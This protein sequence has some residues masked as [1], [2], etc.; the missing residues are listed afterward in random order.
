MAS[1]FDKTQF[2]AAPRD[3]R[4]RM[5]D[6]I[7][8]ALLTYT[9]I[10]IML[11]IEQLKRHDGTFLPY[12][13]LVVLVGGVMPACRWMERRWERIGPVGGLDP[14]FAPRFRK[15][16]ALLWLA[17]IALPCSIAALAR[18]A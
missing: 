18:I 10:Q 5:S 16:R 11:T 9:A 1:G 13:A 4:K 8:F 3:W 6:N 15:E 12:L 7:A 2:R 17:A 14:A